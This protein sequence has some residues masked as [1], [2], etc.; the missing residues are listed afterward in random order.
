MRKIIQIAIAGH[1]NV[2]TTQCNFTIIALADDG[3]LWE[4]DNYT[5]R[6]S[7]DR[8]VWNRLPSLPVE[9]P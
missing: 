7:E 2:S 6:L 8:Q 4:T 3:T 5:M 9:R 1:E